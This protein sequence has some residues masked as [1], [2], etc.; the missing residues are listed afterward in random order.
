M[1][2]VQL[3]E[4]ERGNMDPLNNYVKAFGTYLQSLNKSHYTI[5]QYT[6]DAKQFAS[7]I[8]EQQTL[9]VALQHYVKII[10]ETYTPS[11]SINRKFASV[12]HFLGF[13]QLRGVIHTYHTEILQPLPKEEKKLPVLTE[14]QLFQTI[15][16]WPKKYETALNEEDEWLALRNTTIVFVIAELGIKPAE[17]VRMEW[18]HLH[19]DENEVTIVSTKTFRIL[20][21]STKL[22]ELLKRYKEG[23]QK[24]MPLV[25]EA[26]HIWLGV[27]NKKG[28][29]ITVKTIERIFK[30]MSMQLEFKV[31]AT[32]I[33]YYA[34]HRELNDTDE[35]NEL[36]EQF[37]YARKGVLTERQ[38]R[39]K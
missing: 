24:F 15:S 13:L 16:F 23:T 27:G 8:E 29:P 14:K 32:N 35:T 20:K 1:N 25:L 5:K 33:R 2:M 39:F 31:T 19:I 21:V 37:G 18:R 38:Q 36:Y 11:N 22:I 3:Y 7:I 12:R 30:A 10:K 9:D 17:L 4:K 34:I 6:L 28:E 26:S